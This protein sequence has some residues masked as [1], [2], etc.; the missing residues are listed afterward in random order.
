MESIFDAIVHVE[1]TIL[2]SELFTTDRHLWEKKSERI[3]QVLELALEG[4]EKEEITSVFIPTHNLLTT[5]SVCP[6]RH[7]ESSEGIGSGART[8]RRRGEKT[9]DLGSK[10]DRFAGFRNLKPPCW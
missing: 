8:K 1:L 7:V 9:T 5:A 6:G 10:N 4:V 3:V 2:L